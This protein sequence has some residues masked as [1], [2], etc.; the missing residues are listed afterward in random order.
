MKYKNKETGKI[1]KAIYIKDNI[2]SMR[3]ALKFIG[4][5]VSEDNSPGYA[6]HYTVLGMAG[7]KIDSCK[8]AHI[9]D[10]IV[11]YND[12]SLGVFQRDEFKKC[13]KSVDSINSISMKLDLDTDEYLELLEEGKRTAEKLKDII[14]RLNN[15]NIETNMESRLSMKATIKPGK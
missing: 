14:N 2:A 3:K 15:P 13:F 12:G 4:K 8:V 10:Y 5:D 9:G 1:V 11:K 7:I 6:L